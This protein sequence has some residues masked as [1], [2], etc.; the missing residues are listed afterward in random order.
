MNPFRHIRERI[1]K[2]AARALRRRLQRPPV[3]AADLGDLRRLTPIDAA[4]GYGRGRPID[5]HYI[6]AF[7]EEHSGDVRG[8]VLE[9]GDSTYTKRFGGDAVTAAEILDGNPGATHATYVD[10]LAVGATLPEDAFD[11]FVCT[12][13]LH[14]IPDDAAALRTARRVLRPG[15][16]LLITVPTISRIVY[17][18]SREWGDYWR[19][20]ED[21]LRHRLADAFGG[22]AVE[23]RSYG[24]VLTC[25]ALLYGLAA[26]ELSPEELAHEDDRFPMVIAGRAV[27]R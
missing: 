20:T 8:G 19:Y 5:R 14:L 3:G 4:W 9:I 26:G 16:V 11:C 23:V 13:T 2:P 10:D 27:K 6:E 15:G 1:A 18:E 12:Q 25:T 24:N 7:L 21:G 17:G 22:D